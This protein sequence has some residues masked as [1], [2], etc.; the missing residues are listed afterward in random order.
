MSKK[1]ERQ[2]EDDDFVPLDPEEQARVNQE[3][4][5]ACEEVSFDGVKAALRKGAF[6]NALFSESLQTGLHLVCSCEDEEWWPAAAEV[7]KLLL[8]PGFSPTTHDMDGQNS[9]HLACRYSSSAV[10]KLL[11][12]A[13]PCLVNQE[14]GLVRSRWLH[15]TPLVICCKRGDEEAVAVASLLLDSGAKVNRRA[16]KWRPLQMASKKGRPEVV[17]LLLSRG[18]DVE[19]RTDKAQT[20]LQMA[21]SNGAFGRDIIP[22]LH[23]AGAKLNENDGIAAL[24]RAST[25]SFAM[26]ERVVPL[27]PPAFC[28]VNSMWEDSVGDPVGSL[29][30]ALTHR[31]LFRQSIIDAD[32]DVIDHYHD[33]MWAKLR[34]SK[35]WTRANPLTEI[36]QDAV[37]YWGSVELWK[38]ASS[39]PLMQQNPA[40]GDTFFHLLC[41]TSQLTLL[42]KLD[43]LADL[44]RHHR[45]PLQPNWKGELCIDVATDEALKAELR[46][47]MQWQPNR[48]VTEWF[49]PLFQQRAFTMLLVMKRLQKQYPK[50]GVTLNKDL[51][52]LLVRYLSRV[53]HI[54]VHEKRSATSTV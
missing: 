2:K 1:R 33:A 13:F 26:V 38:W 32:M 22:L 28:E 23:A 20:A 47:Y 12:D 4:L 27:L 7:V 3:L 29:K 8:S 46:Q 35:F 39:E 53:E 36:F 10:V 31:T 42:Q 49:G 54:Y 40:T 50:R 34:Y 52:L 6:V 43:V 11:L 51:R 5:D 24:Q 21:C 15:Y 25:S 41:K 48:L 45:N 16:P 30:A 19:A 14:V 17:S 37:A 9:V 18:A 44:K